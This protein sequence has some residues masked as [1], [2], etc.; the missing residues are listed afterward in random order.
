MARHIL[1]VDIGHNHLNA[2]VFQS[3]TVEPL[4]AASSSL[5]GAGDS[6][7][8]LKES[9][10]AVLRDLEE[11]GYKEFHKV[12]LSI[13]ATEMSLRILSLP[14]EDRRRVIEVLPLELEGLL[15]P[16]GEGFVY[17]ALLLG[18]GKVMAIAVEKGILKG[19]LELLNGMGLDPS[20]IGSSLFSI[21]H[22]PELRGGGVVAFVGKDEVVAVSEGIPKFLKQVTGEEDLRLSLGYME[23]EGLGLEKIYT[24]RGMEEDV[25]GLMPDISVKAL[26]LPDGFP[27]N[28]VG[29][30]AISLHL[31]H[32]LRDS[33]DLRSGEFEFTKE[34]V[35]AKKQIILSGIL[36]AVII[37]LLFGDGLIR[38]FKI[39][40]E[41]RSYERSLR[42]GY[43]ELFPEE[44][45]VVDELLQLEIKLKEQR[46]KRDILSQGVGV[47]EVMNRLARVVADNPDRSI[48]F[49]EM[50][51]AAGKVTV[52]GEVGGVE[53]TSIM[54]DAL[55]SD[56]FFREVML[57]DVN[58]GLEGKTNFSLTMVLQE[59]GM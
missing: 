48:R 47:L 19:Y 8:E 38:Y 33:V 18:E 22:L 42:E 36:I 2:G 23:S 58:T 53:D 30:F 27:E 31:K 50:R 9:L 46:E 25:R 15:Q 11:R 20:W 21:S 45:N 40:G 59:E 5:S 55:S 1:I 13:P 7:K 26:S 44:K 4:C 35:A 52:K 57:T 10:A 3:G 49:S 51:A 17:E 39:A 29:L 54:R 41:I 6:G 28:G 56:E 34:K 32:G 43:L 12:L 24:L 37:G 14:F 16:S